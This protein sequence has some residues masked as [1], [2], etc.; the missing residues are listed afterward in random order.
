MMQTLRGL[1]CQKPRTHGSIVCVGSCRISYPQQLD[2]LPRSLLMGDS[3]GGLALAAAA[4]TQALIEAP[5]PKVGSLGSSVVPF[6]P[7]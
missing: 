3:T 7:F 5:S 6:C 4:S 1:M 2:C